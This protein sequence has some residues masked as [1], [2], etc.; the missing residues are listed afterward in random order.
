[1]NRKGKNKN[2][3]E[4]S[5]SSNNNTKF[6]SLNEKYTETIEKLEFYKKKDYKV[7]IIWECEFKK[8]RR[9]N[10]HLNNYIE[11]RYKYYEFT[12]LKGNINIKN[13]FF[14]GRTNNLQFYK[15]IECNQEIKYLDFCSLYP[16]V[17]RK[18]A[19]PVDHPNIITE[20]FDYSLNSYFGFVWCR[21]EAPRELYLPVLPVVINKRLMFPLC[22][23]C[24]K[25]N[26]DEC[27]CEDRSFEGTWTSI[28]M[29]KAIEVGYEIKEIYQVLTFE[30]K[31]GLFR[32]YVD[33]FLKIKQESSGWPNWVKSEDDKQKYIQDYEINQGIK[34]DYTKIQKNEG[35]RFIAKIML[36]SF[37]GKLAQRPNLSKTSI[38]GTYDEYDKI[39]SDS[40]IEVTGEFMVNEDTCIVSWKFKEDEDDNVYNY[41][42]AV[43]SF[44]TA[45]ARLELLN[46]MERIEKIRPFSVLYHDTDS[47]IYY[48]DLN[49]E[50]IKCGDYLGDLTDEILKEYGEGSIC[51]EF[52]SLGPKNYGYTVKTASNE[53]TSVIK[54][55]GVSLSDIAT[56]NINIKKMI[57]LAVSYSIEGKKDEIHILQ[58]QFTINRH[59]QVFT[60]YFEKVYRAVSEKRVIKGNLTLPF[61]Y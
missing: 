30:K 29:Q 35:L 44:V 2:R 8:E 22:V 34:L 43:A 24:A 33:M 42:I 59:S 51:H 6:H 48:R 13:S 39:I 61:G 36:N 26:N 31:F 19:Y 15:S 40:K 23:K 4:K 47:V 41:N 21:V 18:Y 57:D 58:R 50:K 7:Q 16:Y 37:W 52:V 1:L 27:F 54:C 32:K 28:E 14:G 45:Y 38:C 49:D 3:D 60:R 11:N 10:S 25:E 20:N 17:L 56:N 12:N 46:L 5:I 55:K 53:N 9:N